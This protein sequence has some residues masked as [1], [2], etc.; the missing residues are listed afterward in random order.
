MTIVI[1]T[2]EQ[3][4]LADLVEL[5]HAAF[6]AEELTADELLC[7]TFADGP[8]DAA[9]PRSAIV[10][11]SNDGDAAI[12][13][14]LRD[15]TR[16]PIAHVQFVAVHPGARRQGL[17]RALL[18]A[19]ED[20]AREQE[21]NE[22]ALGA[23]APFYL[24]PGVDVRWTPALCLAE[25]ADFGVRG[26]ELNL[27]CP[28][29]FRAEAPDGVEIRRATGES[30]AQATVAFAE[31]ACPSWVPELERSLDHASAFGAFVDD[32]A[33]A[34]ACHSVNRMGWIGPMAVDPAHGGR[35]IGSALLG[36]VCRDLMVAGY[37]TAEIAW[38]GPVSFYAK[39]AGASVSRVFRTF[40]KTLQ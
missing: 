19:M 25:A 17:G 13:A 29:T 21:A 15:S 12:A 22:L 14:I 11:G 39:A 6:P 28:T 26:A 8:T 16:G 31:L 2:W 23:A 37:R 24:W 7:C 36:E 4:R 32:T 1:D 3:D 5:A 9:R 20:W 18:V 40:A 10:L 33:V 34:F 38:V 35:G 30:D 27:S